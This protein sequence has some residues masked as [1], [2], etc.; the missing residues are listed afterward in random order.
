MEFEHG[1]WRVSLLWPSSCK[2]LLWVLLVAF[3]ASALAEGGLTGSNT[4]GLEAGATFGAS[5]RSTRGPTLHSGSALVELERAVVMF[6]GE[7]LVCGVLKLSLTELA[8]VE[9]S[10]FIAGFRVSA[11]A[12]LFSRE[13]R[14]DEE[15]EEEWT[16][17]RKYRAKI[18]FTKRVVRVKVKEKTMAGVLQC[19]KQKS[20]Q[21]KC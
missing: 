9:G 12:G 14:E 10:K 15:E 8:A 1:A 13:N 7:G 21:S 17:E 11:A 6:L 19:K 18:F 4:G 2:S 20:I 3:T 16:Q 5:L